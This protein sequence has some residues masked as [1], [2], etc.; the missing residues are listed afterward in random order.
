MRTGPD[1]LALFD[2]G[3]RAEMTMPTNSSSRL[4]AMPITVPRSPLFSNSNSTNS[5]DMTADGRRPCD[6]VADLHDR[7]NV[8]RP[9]RLAEALYFFLYY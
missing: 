7:A 5:E 6:A 1:R 4:R 3:V 9:H 2:D 8:Y